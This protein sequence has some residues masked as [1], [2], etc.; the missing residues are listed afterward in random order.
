MEPKLKAQTEWGWPI[1]AYLFLAGVGAGAYAWGALGE[2]TGALGDVAPRVGVMLGFPLLLIGT[3]FLI[4]DL[5]VKPRAL[6]AF[7]SPRTSWIARGTWIISIFMVLSLIHAAGWVWPLG[8]L[9]EAEGLR[10]FLSG[11]TLIFAILTMVYTGVLLGASRPIAIWS[12]AMLPALFLVSALSTG[13]MAVALGTVLV[14]MAGT[15]VAEATLVRMAGLDILAIVAEMLV[16]V[17]YVQ[18]AHATP[19]SRASRELLLR[20]RVAVPFWVGVIGVGLTV[21]L[22]IQVFE[23]TSGETAAGALLS[24]Q[25]ALMAVVASLLGLLGGL[26]LRYV[27]LACGVR[28]PLRAGG[29]EYSFPAPPIV[30]R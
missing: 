9:A 1:A 26:L 14:G 13:L 10:Q 15:P 16:I 5:G 17:F 2:L 11:L 18:A 30:V 25:A 6:N 7:L 20:G 4:G 22:I 23:Y 12:T 3:F 21:P 19:E 24:N 27:V 8:F 28:A 29:I